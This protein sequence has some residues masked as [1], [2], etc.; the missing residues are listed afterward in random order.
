MEGGGGGVIHATHVW[1]MNPMCHVFGLGNAWS[2]Q[3][4]N[5][6][7]TALCDHYYTHMQAC[8]ACGYARH[9]VFSIS[10]F[11]VHIV[12]LDRWR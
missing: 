3:V 9:A 4:W 11:H 1:R 6:R 7:T 8:Q 5:L 2:Y 12:L 10:R